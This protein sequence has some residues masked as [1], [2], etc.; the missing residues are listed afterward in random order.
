MS[1]F[2][3]L[4]LHVWL[5]NGYSYSEDRVEEYRRILIFRKHEK[6]IQML[7]ETRLK[8]TTRET[9]CLWLMCS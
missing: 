8:K 3:Q 5:L 7:L 1:R 4:M 2:K 6:R 9:Q